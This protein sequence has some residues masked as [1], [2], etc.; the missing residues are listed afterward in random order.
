M[1]PDARPARPLS[2]GLA[3]ASLGMLTL[4]V[5]VTRLFSL[6]V[7]YHFAFLAIALALLGFTAGGVLVHLRPKKFDDR[8]GELCL[9]AAGSVVG[10]LLVCAH[11]PLGPSVVAG[12]DQ[13]FLFA[14]VIAV[15]LVPFVLAGIV[16]SATL[17]AHPAH[18]ARLYF[19]DLCG[20]GLGCIVSLLAM[21]T[22]GGGAGGMLVAAIAFA[23][24]AVSFGWESPLRAR[25]LVA[26]PVGAAL[27]FL[28]RQPLQEPFYLPNAKLY[29]R[30]PKPMIL[31]RTCT[32][33]ACVDLF[34]NPL[35]FG[36]WGMS[37][38]YKGPLP[39]QIGVVIDAW[40]I[41]SIVKSEHGEMQHPALEALPPAV[42][43]H[44]NRATRKAPPDML[45]I[46]TGGGLDVR[47][48]LHFKA[49]HVDGVDINPTIV[50]AVRGPWND[51]AG[52][53]YHRPDVSITI[54]EGRHF[55][56]RSEKKWDLVQISG[57]DTYAASQ[58]GAFALSENYLYTVEAFREYL[59]HLG[60]DGTLAL[61]RWLYDPPR[62]TLR[63]VAIADRAMREM[64]LGDG[65]PRIVVIGAPVPD[66]TIDFS[67][68]LVRRTPFTR[69]ELEALRK[70]ADAMAYKMVFSPDG[71]SPKNAFSDYFAASD[72]QAF[73]AAYP[74]RVEP[75]T[76][77]APFFFEHNRWSKLFS[78]RDAIFGAA[79]GPL[80]LLVTL[81]IVSALGAGLGVVAVR[82]TNF[83]A[84]DVLYFVGLGLGYIA[85]ELAFVPRFVLF[86]G[87]PSHALSVVLFAMLIASGIG[88]ALSPKVA[89]DARRVAIVAAAI[90]LLALAYPIVLPRV[91]DAA[92]RF[93]FGVRVVIAVLLVALPSTLMGM[94]FPAALA[95]RDSDAVARAWVLNG[96]AS[97]VASVGTM[98]LAISS[99]FAVVLAFAAACYVVVAL[100]ALRGATNPAS[101]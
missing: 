34:Q 86:L 68:V 29:P 7:W 41:T 100:C 75:T 32:S 28:A 71:S 91:F 78:S 82:R 92:L 4:Q 72:K 64:G 99:G 10:A 22:F 52:G 73:F 13:I 56:R 51:F 60:D 74:F 67:I 37:Q 55:L 8:A 49:R 63:L 33:L 98:V 6:L 76:D 24:A 77:D 9:W 38:K 97:V 85:I 80:V 88:S 44:F 11:L 27:L 79:S 59:A 62:Q 18:A 57:V 19:A 39:E 95:R 93:S 66:S 89:F 81:A 30:V 101:A 50:E 35:H 96:I 46:G 65:G 25:A 12:W 15:L 47:T 54:A 58:A 42:V 83:R 48:A 17:A 69:G 61:T 40:A 45:V 36:L 14:L 53:L 16:V 84:V 87:H 20:S 70:I 1:T 43:H 94:P 3:L 5:S 26:L 90:A 21:D 23:G 2:L 31:S